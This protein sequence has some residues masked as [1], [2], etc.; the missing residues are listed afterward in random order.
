ML[1]ED[2]EFV[3]REKVEAIVK[4]CD[5]NVP[6][7]DLGTVFKSEPRCRVEDFQ[8]WLLQHPH[9]A[10]FSSWLLIED[11]PGFSLEGVKDALSFYETLGQ[12]FGGENTNTS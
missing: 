6:G 7:A 8:H 4:A 5:S 1:S 3:V 9:M 10:S 12:K 11:S 2:G